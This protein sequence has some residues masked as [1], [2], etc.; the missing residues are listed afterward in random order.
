MT[1]ESVLMDRLTG[2]PPPPPT[3]PRVVVSRLARGETGLA[4]TALSVKLVLDGEEVYQIDGRTHRLTP[5][6]LLLV[7]G[8]APY[9]ATIRSGLTR[10]LCVHLPGI[11]P[12]SCPVVALPLGRAMLRSTAGVG[13]GEELVALARMVHEDRLAPEAAAARIVDVASAAI[14][15]GRADA[16]DQMKRLSLKRA[17]TRQDV[18]NRLELARAHLH[19]VLDRAVPLGELADIAGISSFHLARYFAA[20]F[21]APPVRYHRSL[22]LRRASELLR[23]GLS[24]TEAAE[25]VGYAELAAFSHA[26]RREFGRPPSLA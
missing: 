26:F 8:G 22:R 10:G 6:R 2:T 23:S 25:R 5:G 18:L 12:P 21:G 14:R 9:E 15:G 20:A 3:V 24:A 17:S 7:D 16:A 13:G 1:V 19:A 11:A 4:G